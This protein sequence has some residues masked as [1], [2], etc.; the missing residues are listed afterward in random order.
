MITEH[1]AVVAA[2]AE[3]DPDEAEA[4]LRHHLRMV[5]REIPRLRSEHP[6][7]FEEP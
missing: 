2:V 7:F 4:R 3:H 6:D 1:R 5:L